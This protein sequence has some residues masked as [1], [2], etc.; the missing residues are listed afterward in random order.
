MPPAQTPLPGV[1]APHKHHTC[2]YTKSVGQSVSHITA[3]QSDATPHPRSSRTA[4]RTVHCST[5]PHMRS[6]SRSVPPYPRR[7]LLAAADAPAA[8]RRAL[9]AGCLPPDSARSATSLVSFSTAL[10]IVFV[11]SLGTSW[12]RKTRWYELA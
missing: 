4:H 8:D 2:T 7:G 12:P 3:H 6:R 1:S 9:A 10:V 5:A 11:F